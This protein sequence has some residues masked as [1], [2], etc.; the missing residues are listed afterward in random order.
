[1]K[2]ALNFLPSALAEWGAL[3]N[4]VRVKLKKILE[5]RLKEPRVPSARL[6]AGARELYKIK[7]KNPGFRLVY[8]VVDE[9]VTITVITVGKRDKVYQ[10][11]EK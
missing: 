2:Y 4:S 8:E 1:M 6:R 10:S 11:I 9:T 3:D 5:K 7:L